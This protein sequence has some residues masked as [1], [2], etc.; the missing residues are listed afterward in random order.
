MPL[1]IEDYALIGNTRT[2]ALVGID[3]SID[4]MCV[5]RFDSTACFAALLGE[6]QHGRWVLAPAGAARS[7]RR[8]Y[9]PD[10]LVLETEFQT[11]DGVARVIDCMP[12]WENRNDVV[13]VVQGV[14]G[15]VPM[16]MELIIRPGYGAITPWVRR[17]D[18][19]LLATAGPDSLELRTSVETE[20]RYFTT[21][22]EFTVAAGQRIPFVLTCF[23]SHESRPLPVDADASIAATERF[24]RAWCGHCSYEGR[25]SD[26]VRT[27]TIVLKALIYAPTGGMVAAATTSLPERIG[28]NRNWDYRFCWVR[29]AT[30]ALYALLLSGYHDEARA[31]QQ[32]LLRAAAGHPADLQVLYGVAAEREL[33]EQELP[34]LPGYLQ[35][36]PVR[37]GNAAASQLQL[38]IYGELMDALCVARKAGLADDDDGWSFQRTLV[39]FLESNWQ[40]ADSGIWEMRGEPR[41]FTH[42]KVMCWVAMDRAIEAV[43]KYGL[44][45]PVERWRDVRAR[46]HAD[47]CENGYDAARGT[48]VQSYGSSEL[49]ASLLLIPQVGFLPAPDPRVRGTVEAIEREL[50]VDGLVLRY[51]THGGVDGLPAGEGH[52]LPCSF[53]LADA[54]AL[55]GRQADA[56]ALFERLLALRND[57]GLLSEEYDLRNRR[58]LGNTPQSMTH[59]ALINTARNLSERGGPAE[60]RSSSSE[61]APP[62]GPAKPASPTPNE[63]PTQRQRTNRPDAAQGPRVGIERGPKSIS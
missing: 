5:P 43:E 57:V 31:W 50:V 44:D 42:S 61:A 51:R 54:L 17:V 60:H 22:A 55:L 39:T 47:V 6:P 56:E 23:P 28:G 19:A 4:W 12:M 32:W 3:G 20:G 24:W 14:S 1:P 25:W 40:R 36:A 46:I 38:D 11:A 26:A 48:F 34:W 30:F 37:I 29:D 33:T 45:G 15:A 35:S 49:D 10:T 18:D 8:A 52:F 27:S 59:M 9:R 2:A 7:V 63:P 62:G 21:V 53:W 41:H 13:R 16:R 58:A